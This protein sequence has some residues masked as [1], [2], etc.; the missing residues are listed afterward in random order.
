VLERLQVLDV[1]KTAPGTILEEGVTLKALTDIIAGTN[2]FNFPVVNEQG[3]FSGILALQDVRRLLFEDALYDIVLV[4]D[5][6][7]KPVYVRLDYD[8]YAA[9]M[10]FVG[11]DLSQIPVLDADNE[12][13]G[14]LSR[15]AVFKAYSEAIKSLE[16]DDHPHHE[17]G[18]ALPRGKT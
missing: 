16:E 4:K 6:A 14:T 2:E 7:R 18:G 15:E 12:I 5:L 10:R 11:T 8:L 17:G 3:E 9:L 1:Y 13:V